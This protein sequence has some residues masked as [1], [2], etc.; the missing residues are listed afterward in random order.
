MKF[1]ERLTGGQSVSFGCS[2][3][4]QLFGQKGR[5]MEKEYPLSEKYMLS[6]NEA[7]TYFS[8]G[9]KK[10]RR[11]AEENRGRFSVYSGNRYLINRAKFEN[12]LLNS[13][14]V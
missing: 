6:V 13:S 9:V 5:T 3:F 7:A 4:I 2:P 14:E 8:I 1:S 11:L 10:M 12:F